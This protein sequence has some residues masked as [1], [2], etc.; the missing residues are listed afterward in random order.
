M[1]K[2]DLQ[3][4]AAI[5]ADAWQMGTELIELPE[6]CRPRS[7]AAG[8]QL[9]DALAEQ[10]G[11]EV[12]GW[13]IG[14]TSDYAQKLLKTDGPFAGRV[15]AP[16]LNRNGAI[17]PGPAYQMRGLEGEFAFVMG[18]DLKPRKRPYTRAEVKDAV[19]E[20]RLAIEV[21]DSRFTDW[22]GV[23]TPCLIADMGCNAALVVSE[24]V[25]G[26]K[27]IDLT[28]ATAKMKVD[29][30]VVGSGKGADALGD[31]LLA[32]TWLAN[33]LRERQGLKVGQIVSTGTCTGFYKAPEKAKV[34]GDFGKLGKVSLTFV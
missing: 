31:P 16:R 18:K 19:A 24:P 8:M 10:L 13:K 22:L 15:F 5:L 21:V 9:Q 26:W 7:V 17:L 2:K 3:R 11:F 14:C 33:L 34:V 30:K 1:K 23:G 6:E 20:L 32:L 27:K 28:K 29:G 25:K 4:A 12:A